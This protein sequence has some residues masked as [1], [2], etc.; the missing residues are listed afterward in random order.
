MMTFANFASVSANNS[1]LSELESDKSYHLNL[2]HTESK[3]KWQTS[4][5][6]M[7]SVDMRNVI[8]KE[9]V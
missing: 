2:H 8:Y 3:Q 1:G 7:D 5:T 4:L 6:K 9:V